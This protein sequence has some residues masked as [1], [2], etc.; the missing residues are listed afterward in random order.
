[1]DRHNLHSLNKP[2]YRPEVQHQD[3]RP[4]LDLCLSEVGIASFRKTT[5]QHILSFKENLYSL[6]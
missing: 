2:L 3:D 1:M 4:I 6:L 5:E